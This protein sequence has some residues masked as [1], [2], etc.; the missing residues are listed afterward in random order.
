MVKLRL[1]RMGKKN[2][3]LY[4][5]VAADSRSP[6]DGKFI[7]SVGHYNPHLE[8]MQITLKE[9]RVIY[10]LKN[11]A[12]P[13]DTVRSL[14]KKEGVMMK[15]R[16]MKSKISPEKMEEKMNLFFEDKPAKQQRAK[17]RKLRYK[18]TKAKKAETKT[19]EAKA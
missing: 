8:P 13:T 5:I 3:P 17:A 7:E 4:K 2:I 14:L 19:E 1:K 6:R 18:E 11:G 9:D 12:K 10:W 16:L 15:F